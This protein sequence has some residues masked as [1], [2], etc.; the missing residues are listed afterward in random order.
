MNYQNI[1]NLLEE[2]T[3]QPSKFRTRNWVEI[4]DE[5]KGRYDKSNI[6]LKRSIISWNLCDESD[7]YIFV[8][9]T[10]TVPNTAAAGAAVSNTNKKVIFKN[11]TTFTNCIT[12]INNPQ[13]DNPQKVDVVIPIYN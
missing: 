11:C 1:I 2:T 5:W 7:S 12:E 10:I 8:T 9:G 4:N 3:Y 6:R 13:I